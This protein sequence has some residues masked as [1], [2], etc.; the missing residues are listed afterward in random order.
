VSQST[1]TLVGNLVADPERRR[2]QSGTSVTSLRIA[3]TERHVDKATGQWVD[4]DTT[5][6]SAVCWRG[7]ADNVARSLRRGDRIILLGRLRERDL[8]SRDGDERVTYE[9]DVSE[10]G[11]ELTF[12]TVSVHKA[13]SGRERDR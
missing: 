7:L 13:R 1:I 12:A 2:T 8:P 11:A 10:I 9:I 6:V 3:S 4:G 5:H